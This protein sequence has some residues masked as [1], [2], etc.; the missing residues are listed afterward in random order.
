VSED[1]VNLRSAFLAIMVSC[2]TVIAMTGAAFGE[3]VYVAAKSAQLRSGKTSLDPVVASVKLGETLEVVTRDDRWLQVQTTKGVK[4]WIYHNNVSASKPSGGNTELAALG[5]SFRQ[6]DAS[7]VTASAG[8]R[9]LDKTSEVYA[10]RSG[11]TQQQRDAVDR[12]TA[13]KVSDEDI[14]Q[15][16]KS[17]RLGEYAE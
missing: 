9:G 5:K 6:T 17:G 15:F 1:F 10:R 3:S 4:G 12:M 7:D 14:Q 16:L 13:Y 11:I 2:V 8:A